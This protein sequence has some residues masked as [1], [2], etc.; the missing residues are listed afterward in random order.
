MSTWNNNCS[1]CGSLNY[2]KLCDLE[3]NFCIYVIALPCG[4]DQSLDKMFQ[5]SHVIA[6]IDQKGQK[7]DLWGQQRRATATEILV[8][9][10]YGGFNQWFCLP[11]LLQI[12]MIG[13]YTHIMKITARSM[14]SKLSEWREEEKQRKINK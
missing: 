13:M 1:K 9:Y 7:L 12:H 3:N 4:V 10:F 6:T 5:K 2:E 11:N 8:S 14:K